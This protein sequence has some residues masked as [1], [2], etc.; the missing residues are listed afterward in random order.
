METSFC[1]L[2]AAQTAARSLAIEFHIAKSSIE[3]I[4]NTHKTLAE[5]FLI[6]NCCKYCSQDSSIV[7]LRIAITA[8]ETL[9]RI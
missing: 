4:D 2:I 7:E 8:A 5:E 3:N 6:A 1:T 9:A